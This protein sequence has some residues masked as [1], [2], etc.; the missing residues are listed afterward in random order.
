MPDDRHAAEDVVDGGPL[1]GGD[2]ESL[3]ERVQAALWDTR[4]AAEDETIEVRES[5]YDSGYT[6]GVKEGKEDMRA[7]L[8]DLVDAM[9]G[10]ISGVAFEYLHDR[11]KRL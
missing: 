5:S 8:L 4:A 9:K 3:V 6:D 7:E 10:K 2:R 1:D 11:A